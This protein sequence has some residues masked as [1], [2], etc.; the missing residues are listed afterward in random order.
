MNAYV[1]CLT[2]TRLSKRLQVCVYACAAGMDPRCVAE[3]LLYSIFS[4]PWARMRMKVLLPVRP[5]TG[6]N[7]SIYQG[8]EH[9]LESH[10]VTP[11]PPRGRFAS[12]ALPPS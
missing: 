4:A 9:L 11:G 3:T 6:K 1:K 7:P 2:T 5:S 8:A 12:S 10:N